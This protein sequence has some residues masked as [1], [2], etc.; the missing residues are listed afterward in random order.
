MTDTRNHVFH[1]EITNRL[2]QQSEIVRVHGLIN[3]TEVLQRQME[4]LLVHAECLI[5]RRFLEY[6]T[7]NMAKIRP[8]K[9]LIR[10]KVK[11]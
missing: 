10:L 7:E 3:G 1:N 9:S 11:D 8:G 4:A 5:V 2:I 6:E